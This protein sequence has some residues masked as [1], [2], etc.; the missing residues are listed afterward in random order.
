MFPKIKIEEYV[1]SELSDIFS[2]KT[3]GQYSAQV[4]GNPFSCI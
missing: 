4:N 1:G 2:I 3:Y